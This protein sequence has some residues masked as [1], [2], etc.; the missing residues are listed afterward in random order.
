MTKHTPGFDELQNLCERLEMLLVD[1]QPGLSSWML[2]LS[3]VCL[4]IGDYGGIGKVSAM[5]DL[6]AACKAMLAHEYAAKPAKHPDALK[7]FREETLR[8]AQS[9]RLAKTAIARAE[10]EAK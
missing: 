6:L 3:E 2:K 8:G 10:P 5:P 9:R 4:A 7:W 1:R